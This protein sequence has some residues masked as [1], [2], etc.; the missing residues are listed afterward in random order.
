MFKIGDKVK[1][2]SKSV[3]KDITRVDYREGF[4]NNFDFFDGKQVV[5][6][7]YRRDRTG[8]FFLPEDLDFFELPLKNQI[9]QMFDDLINEL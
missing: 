3:G 9:D 2:L 7:Y 8:D 5:I 1:I 6:V 4:V